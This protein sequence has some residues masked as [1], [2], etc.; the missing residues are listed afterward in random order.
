MARAP[1]SLRQHE[2]SD[3]D[4]EAFR[5]SLLELI[6]NTVNYVGGGELVQ[7]RLSFIDDFYYSYD[8]VSG[9]HSGSQLDPVAAK[10]K[11]VQ[12]SPLFQSA[13][14]CASDGSVLDLLDCAEDHRRGAL[15]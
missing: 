15:D 9:S 1:I 7:M 6:H 11:I 14:L 3:R 5:I 2:F 4:I 12:A 13:E 10:I 8:Q